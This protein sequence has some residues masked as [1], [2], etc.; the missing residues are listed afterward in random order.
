M[1]A[2]K[3]SNNDL[4]RMTAKQESR[5]YKTGKFPVNPE[6]FLKPFPFFDENF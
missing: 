4:N 6:I 5:G 2:R 1:V 3:T